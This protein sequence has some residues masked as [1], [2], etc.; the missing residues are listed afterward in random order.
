MILNSIQEEIILDTFFINIDYPGWPN[1]AKKLLSKGTCVVAGASCIWLGGIGNFI[2][3]KKEPDLVGCL[4]YTFDL[5]K[6]METD[7][8]KS[9]IQ[10]ITKSRKEEIDTLQKEMESINSLLKM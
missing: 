7:Y 9:G 10:T 4:R 5:D 1:V 3:T 2:D 8:F 6:F